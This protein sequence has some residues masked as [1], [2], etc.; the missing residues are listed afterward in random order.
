MNHRLEDSIANPTRRP[1][2][3]ST[4]APALSF[5][6]CFGSSYKV[7]SKAAWGDSVREETSRTFANPHRRGLGRHGAGRSYYPDQYYPRAP[8]YGRSAVVPPYTGHRNPRHGIVRNG[9][10]NGLLGLS[11][12]GKPTHAA[13]VSCVASSSI[14]LTAP[15]LSGTPP[16]T[17]FGAL[18]P[19]GPLV[20]RLCLPST[21]SHPSFTFFYIA[22][23][24][25]ALPLSA[26]TRS[27]HP[28]SSA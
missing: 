7:K 18:P 15:S 4:L 2:Y 13:M 11:L 23:P 28:T 21:C 20:I 8:R 25:L 24:P 14:S 19:L 17:F 9:Y 12:A 3:N 16:P 6:M 27:T 10:S 5:G 1:T 26:P 22:C